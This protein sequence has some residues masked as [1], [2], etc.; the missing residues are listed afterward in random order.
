MAQLQFTDPAVSRAKFARELAEYNALAATYRQRGWLLLDAEYPE[1]LVAFA[2]PKTNPLTLV[3]GVALDYTNYDAAPPSV[4]VVH[5]LTAKPF[6]AS[7]LPTRLDRSLPAQNFTAAPGGPQL[8]VQQQQPY[9]QAH[10]ENE[11]PFLCMAGVREYHDHPAH[12]GDLWE[13]H[14]TDGAGRLVRILE[15]IS[16]YGIEPIAGFRVHMQPMIGLNYG[17]PPE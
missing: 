16:R 10:K 11:I 6:K 5:P 1:V 12:S 13:L 3:M 14:R 8:V 17:P 15:V 4:R 9:M 2:A 7:E